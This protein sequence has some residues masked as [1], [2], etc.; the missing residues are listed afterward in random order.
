MRRQLLGALI[1]LLPALTLSQQVN[2][3]VGKWTGSMAGSSGRELQLE[4][5]ITQAGGAWRFIG[6]AKNNPCLG[7]DFPI[8]VTAQSSTELQIEV[9]G[10]SVLQGCIDETI[11]LRAPDATT[12]EGALADGRTFRLTRQ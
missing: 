12:I 1:M 5:A 4:V 10:S 2:A 11:V 9:K 7:R 6:R 8:S 3:F